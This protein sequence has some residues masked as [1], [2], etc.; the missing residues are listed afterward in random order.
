MDVHRLIG[1]VLNKVQVFSGLFFRGHHRTAERHMH[2]AFKAKFPVIDIMFG[3]KRDDGPNAPCSEPDPPVIAA[4]KAGT[5]ELLRPNYSETFKRAVSVRVML[6]R[7]PVRG[8]CCE[9]S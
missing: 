4:R 5:R 1:R 9:G 7:A 2:H 6:N 8:T 3:T